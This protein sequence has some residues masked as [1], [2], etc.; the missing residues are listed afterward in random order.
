M[1]SKELNPQQWEAVRHTEGPLMVV[2]GAGSGKTRV[3]I[4]RFCWLVD[5][6]EVSPDRILTVTFTKKA[7]SQIKTRLVDGWGA[8]PTTADAA[9]RAPTKNPSRTP[10]SW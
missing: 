4:E 1:F 3:L 9:I 5:E 6:R 2:A 7:A 8:S 10:S